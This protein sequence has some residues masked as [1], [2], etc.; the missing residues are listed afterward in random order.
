MHADRTNRTTLTVLA[1]LLVA[2]G[3]LGGALSL[4]AFGDGAAGRSLGDN[5]VGDFV[6]R[7]SSWFW[8]VVAVAALVLVLL[9]VRWLLAILFSTQRTGDLPVDAGGPG[10]TTLR[11]DAVTR[12]VAGEIDGYSGVVGSDV[13]LV[14]D[15]ERPVLGVAVTVE[16][17]ADLAELRDRIET[18]ALAHARSA[19]A[20]PGLPIRLDLTVT[21]ARGPRVS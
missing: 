21:P 7:E 3:G 18:E 8:P 10:R 13:R 9:C 12:A 6:R 15:A 20:D 14:G 11:P 19:L 4:G 2:A 16:D 1:L 5:A 17:S